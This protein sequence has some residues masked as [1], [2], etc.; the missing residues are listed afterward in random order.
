MVA[1]VLYCLDYGNATLAGIP[2]FLVQRLQSAMDA[3]AWLIYSSTSYMYDQHN[4]I[5]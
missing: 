4:F 5:A 3:A 2:T 1:V